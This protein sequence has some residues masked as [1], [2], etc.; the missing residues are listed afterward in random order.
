MS[1]ASRPASRRT[2]SASSTTESDARQLRDQA[3]LPDADAEEPRTTAYSSPVNTGAMYIGFH[4]SSR[5]RA[6]QRLVARVVDPRAFVVPDDADRR[7]PGRIGGG[8]DSAQGERR[9]RDE[10]Q[11]P[12]KRAG[13]EGP[14]SD[15]GVALRRIQTSKPSGPRRRHVV[16]RAASR[17]SD[18]VVMKNVAE[19]STSGAQS[20]CCSATTAGGCVEVGEQALDAVARPPSL[21]PTITGRLQKNRDALARSAST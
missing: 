3:R 15:H 1:P 19:S 9:E 8:K 7:S 20:R 13:V 5:P 6:E 14:V 17:E 21:K 16:R 10:Q 11:P 4:S 2:P 18:G 12:G